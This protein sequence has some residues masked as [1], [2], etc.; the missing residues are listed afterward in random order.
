[1]RTKHSRRM[2]TNIGKQTKLNTVAITALPVFGT[3]VIV[4][5]KSASIVS[6]E[7]ET[8]HERAW[9]SQQQRSNTQYLLTQ[10]AGA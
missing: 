3:E 9:R 6:I 5:G 1:M 8:F 10:N 4:G 2:H 7:G